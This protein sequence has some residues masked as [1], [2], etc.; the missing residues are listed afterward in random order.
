MEKNKVLKVI[1]IIIAVAVWLIIT[2][3]Y[4]AFL[5]PLWEGRIPVI[6]R[7]ILSSMVV[8]YTLGL[9]A[10]YIIVRGMPEACKKDGK[11]MNLLK[12]FIRF[13]LKLFTIF[14]D[15]LMSGCIVPKDEEAEEVSAVNEETEENN[16]EK[17]E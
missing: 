9:G 2:K 14:N 7:M 13:Y 17:Q 1:R 12:C 15:S 8:P 3:L 16:N 4:G 6:I 5:D 11:T 10:F